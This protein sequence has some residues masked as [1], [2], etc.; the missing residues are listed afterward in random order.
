MAKKKV[1]IPEAISNAIEII[2]LY[3]DECEDTG[4]A[5]AIQ[6]E[7]ES[8]AEEWDEKGTELAED[9]AAEELG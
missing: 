2:R 7:L 6:E 1:V 3:L 9:D 5:C 4:E 8:L